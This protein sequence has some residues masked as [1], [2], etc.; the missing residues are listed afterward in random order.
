MLRVIP[1][2]NRGELELDQ[3]E[4]LL[5]HR[6]AGCRAT[7]SNALG[8]INPV[9][10]IINTAHSW[11]VLVLIDGFQAAP[12]MKVDVRNLD[13]DFYVFSPA[14]KCSGPPASACCMAES[15]CLRTCRPTRV[16]A[17]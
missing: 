15:N 13:C 11:N 2:N 9:R 8:T 14:T 6:S 17:T 3:F 4:K 5:N 12:H 10:K 1:I 16:V 7:S